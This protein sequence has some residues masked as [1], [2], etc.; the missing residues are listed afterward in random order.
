MQCSLQYL[1]SWL[2]FFFQLA[3]LGAWSV[4]S[5]GFLT[6]FF[7]GLLNLAKVF[8]DPLN[9]EDGCECVHIDISVLIRESNAG[10][11]RWKNGAE[12]LPFSM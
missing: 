2:L 10:L 1:D 6:L 12:R 11:V 3:E 4:F 5:V 9:N 7:L 8:L